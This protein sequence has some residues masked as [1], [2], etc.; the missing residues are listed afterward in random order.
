MSFS[1]NRRVPA[2]VNDPN[3]SY[4]PGSPER[5]EIKA[6]LKTMADERINIPLVI[7]GK[8]VRTK[9]MGQAVM[10]HKHAHVLADWHK[11]GPA[12]VRQAI[13]AAAAARRDWANWP[14]EERAA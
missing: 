5:A 10:P 3:L 12:E 6:R 2:A 8:E 7:G 13:R 1:G 4:A 14:W 11:A 9:K